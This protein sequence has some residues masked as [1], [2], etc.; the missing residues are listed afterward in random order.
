MIAAVYQNRDKINITNGNNKGRAK[1]LNDV[2]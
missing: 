1:T 2:T